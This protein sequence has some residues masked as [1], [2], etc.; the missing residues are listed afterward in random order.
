VF[1]YNSFDLKFPLNFTKKASTGFRTHT[2][3]IHAVV[4]SEDIRSSLIVIKEVL[5]QL[6]SSLYTF[7]QESHVS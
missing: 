3:V 6:H 2:P 5:K 7:V 4:R 1:L